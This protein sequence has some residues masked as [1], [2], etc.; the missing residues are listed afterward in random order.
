MEPQQEDEEGYANADKAS[1][2]PSTTLLEKLAEK[3]DKLEA[4][5]V[6]IKANQPY[7]RHLLTNPK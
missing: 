5:M 6:E 4:D 1:V 7:I 2:G 3:V